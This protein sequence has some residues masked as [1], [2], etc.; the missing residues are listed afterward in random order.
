MPLMLSVWTD[1][2]HENMMQRSG[3]NDVE[4]GGEAQPSGH[5]DHGGDR[6]WITSSVLGG[7][8]APNDAPVPYGVMPCRVQI[9]EPGFAR[10]MPVAARPV[11]HR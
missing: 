2:R 3:R 10:A 9:R 5:D 11:P 8:P 7:A 4:Y 6:Y 1:M